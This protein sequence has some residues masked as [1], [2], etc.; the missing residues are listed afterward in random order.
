MACLD[1]ALRRIDHV[2]VEDKRSVGRAGG[3]LVTMTPRSRAEAAA[4]EHGETRRR[5][6]LPVTRPVPAPN[7]GPFRHWI[8][9]TSMSRGSDSVGQRVVTNVGYSPGEAG[10]PAFVDCH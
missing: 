5:W 3:E 8:D 4:S 10:K 9:L 7:A 1:S 2:E 6:Q